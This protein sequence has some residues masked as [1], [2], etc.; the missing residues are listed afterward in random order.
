MFNLLVHY[1][2]KAWE[3][4]QLMT[5]EV[6]RFK[7]Y[8]GGECESIKP[9]DPESLKLLE[10][11]DTLL[12]YESGSDSNPNIKLVRFGYLYEI[13]KLRSE[14]VFRF[15]Q[16]GTLKRSVLVEYAKQLAI[17]SFEFNRTHWAIKDGGIPAQ[18]KAKL[19]RSY[20]VVFSFAGEDRTY[21]EKVAKFLSARNVNVFYDANEQANLWGKDL[22][23][24]LDSVY[25]QG[26]KYCVMFISKHYVE[27]MWTRHERRSALARALVERDEYILP[28]RFDD[29]EVKGIRPTVGHV[30]LTELPP[31]KLGEL[32]LQ[33]LSI[34]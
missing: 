11:I 1:D 19:S 9:L 10:G 7:E 5:M 26:G 28:A 12:M 15:K 4:D 34:E 27:K 18:V 17:D 24:H 30:D 29:S 6:D 2:A 8:S 3:T 13:R 23:E 14:L 16:K 25:Q 21:V 31:A 33:K 22:A 32:I 20:D